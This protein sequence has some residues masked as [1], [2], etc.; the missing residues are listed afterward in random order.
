MDLLR[1][2]VRQRNEHK[3]ALVQVRM[4]HGQ[5]GCVKDKIIVEEYIDVNFTRPIADGGD[6]AQLGL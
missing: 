1:C 4:G 3:G 2:Q 6:A 5:F